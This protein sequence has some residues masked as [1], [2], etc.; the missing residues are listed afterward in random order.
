MRAAVS[1]PL[2]VIA[3][4]SAIFVLI[5]LSTFA[6]KPHLMGDYAYEPS[7]SKAM[8]SESNGETGHD[9]DGAS[10]RREI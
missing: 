2:S 7:F 10:E 5:V 8:K 4:I 1:D 9:Y 6:A 3:L